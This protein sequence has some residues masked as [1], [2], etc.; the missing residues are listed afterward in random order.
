MSYSFEESVLNGNV[1]RSGASFDNG[2]V[3]Y[4][5]GGAVDSSA[6]V[7]RSTTSRA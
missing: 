6:F 5:A 7:T 2:A 4:S 3:L 1:V